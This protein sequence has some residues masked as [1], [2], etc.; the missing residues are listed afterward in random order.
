MKKILLKISVGFMIL[1]GFSNCTVM[2]KSI[3]EPNIRLEMTMED[4]AL[5]KQ[6]SAEAS[7]LKILGIDFER[8]FTQ[9]YGEIERGSKSIN[10]A[11]IPVIGDVIWD[12]TANY[13]LYD[14]MQ[15]N[16]GFDVIIYPQYETKVVRPVLGLGFI[17]KRTK[18]KATARLGKLNR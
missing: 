16:P 3:R 9:R 7:S 6:L 1:T 11:K 18:V 13:A 17:V 8:L 15:E 12:K 4:L 14:L 10:F 5:S 2:S